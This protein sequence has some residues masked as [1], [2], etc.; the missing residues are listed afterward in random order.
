MKNERIKSEHIDSSFYNKNYH[1]QEMTLFEEKTTVIHGWDI[2]K[3]SPAYDFFKNNSSYIG[4]FVEEL[5]VQVAAVA[6]APIIPP[7]AVLRHLLL[8]LDGWIM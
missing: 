3:L 8:L 2:K 4:N 1:P 6:D 5:G 7:E